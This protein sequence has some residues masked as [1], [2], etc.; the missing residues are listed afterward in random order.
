MCQKFNLR[1]IWA[2]LQVLFIFDIIIKSTTHVRLY[3]IFININVVIAI[4]QLEASANN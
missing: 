4:I 2:L 3:F 1:G